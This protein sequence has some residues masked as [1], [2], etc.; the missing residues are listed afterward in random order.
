MIQSFVSVMA[1][2]AILSSAVVTASPLALAKRQ[3]TTVTSTVEA[4]APTPSIWSAGAVTDY[5]IHSSCNHTETLQLQAALDD[6]IALAQHAKDHVLR[7]GNSSD[8]YIKYFGSAA[9]GEVLGWYEKIVRADRAGIWFRCDDPD[10]KC[11][12][13]GMGFR[14]L[15][16]VIFCFA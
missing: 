5:P 4:A 13:A 3:A 16:S 11:H 14:T 2:G 7:F 10:Q 1:L 12:Q 15:G 8:F 9:T 6:A